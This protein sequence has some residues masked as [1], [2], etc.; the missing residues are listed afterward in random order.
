MALQ[1][2]RSLGSRL[3]HL[4]ARVPAAPIESTGPRTEDEWLAAFEAMGAFDRQVSW[5]TARSEFRAAFP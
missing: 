4:E 1:R 3:A 2:G 5:L